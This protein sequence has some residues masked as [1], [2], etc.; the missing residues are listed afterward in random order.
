MRTGAAFV[1][2]HHFNKSSAFTSQAPTAGMTRVRGSSD[3]AAAVDAALSVALSGSRRATTRLITPEKN[4]ELP[5]EPALEFSILSH[6]EDALVLDFTST[7][8]SDPVAV[9]LSAGHQFSPFVLNR[10]FAALPSF[11]GVQSS[12]QGRFKTYESL[13]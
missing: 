6:G 8:T 9:A 1:V 11:P 12:R 2:V 13:A 3:I 5:E 4:R 10:L 7:E